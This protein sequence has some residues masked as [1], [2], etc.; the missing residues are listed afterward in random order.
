MNYTNK[1]P[2]PEAPPLQLS[3]PNTRK[4]K[5]NKENGHNHQSLH[6]YHEKEESS[7]PDKT[8]TVQRFPCPHRTPCQC[9]LICQNHYSY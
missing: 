4:E 8:I 9:S 5:K 6:F 2:P 7:N 3:T 1:I